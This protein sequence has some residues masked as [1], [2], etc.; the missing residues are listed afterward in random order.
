MKKL[1]NITPLLMVALIICTAAFLYLNGCSG[2]G[3]TD[4]NNWLSG[5]TTTP[6]PIPT[7][8]V[9]ATGPADG[10][11]DI[12]LNQAVS[13]TFDRDITSGPDYNAITISDGRGNIAYTPSIDAN[14]LTLTPDD[15]LLDGTTYTVTIPADAVTSARALAQQLIFSFSTLTRTWGA[16]T[17][18]DD[19]AGT[20]GAT[21]PSIGADLSGNC[22][23][24]WRDFRNP[25]TDDIYSSY[26]Q[27]G[28]AW[29]T[30]MR[31]DDAPGATG[32]YYPG[33]ALDPSGNA[34]AVW[35][36]NRNGDWDIYF[37]YRPS[38]GN[39]GYRYT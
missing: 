14:V 37:S 4:L 26:R 2:S 39:W 22:Y 25:P 16:N 8:Q 28:G 12:P 27:S 38:G 35:Q 5:E 36:D 30:N 23:A 9:T 24:V 10:A 20:A 6:T 33:L 13:V 21:V 34:Y 31:V 29:G 3:S 11:T 7:E 18:V 1:L 17:R 15:L 19:D 32:A